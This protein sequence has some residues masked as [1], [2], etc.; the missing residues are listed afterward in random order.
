MMSPIN[1]YYHKTERKEIDFVTYLDLI[2]TYLDLINLQGRIKEW[3][4]ITK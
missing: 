4:I 1:A 3:R 2:V